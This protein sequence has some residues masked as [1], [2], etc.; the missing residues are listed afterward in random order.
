MASYTNQRVRVC[1]VG[2]FAVTLSVPGYT[3]YP[4]DFVST[5]FITKVVYMYNMGL[6]SRPLPSF[7][8]YTKAGRTWLVSSHEHGINTLRF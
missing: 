1:S 7:S 4:H 6:I 2:L 3:V 5:G 8:Q